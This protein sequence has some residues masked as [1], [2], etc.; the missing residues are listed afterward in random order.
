MR[1]AVLWLV[2]GGLLALASPAK[3]LVITEDG[4]TRTGVTARLTTSP[5]LPVTGATTTLEVVTQGVISAPYIVGVRNDLQDFFQVPTK[6]AGGDAFTAQHVFSESGLYQLWSDIGG[7]TWVKHPVTIVGD[8]IGANKRGLTINRQ[9]RVGDYRVSLTASSTLYANTVS[10]LSVS[11]STT[12]SAARVVT[13][14]KDDLSVITQRVIKKPDFKLVFP[15]PGYYKLFVEFRP[16]GAR[17]SPQPYLL[18]TLGVRVV[19]KPT[20]VAKTSWL[21]RIFS[22][23]SPSQ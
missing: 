6:A 5:A 2:L 17:L 19:T 21:Q 10:N 18:A 7:D 8:S 4:V 13:V 3:A 12:T 15:E 16:D 22:I 14:I 11:I 20:E 1:W 9:T 23:F